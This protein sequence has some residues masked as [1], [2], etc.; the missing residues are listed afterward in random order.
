M[1]STAEHLLSIA[2][3]QIGYQ[4]KANNWVKYGTEFGANNEA[5]CQV[6]VWWVFKHSGA[7]S[8]MLQNSVTRIAYPWFKKHHTM[9]PVAQARPGDV[10]WF[11]FSKELKPVSHVGIVEKNLGDGVLQTIEGNTTRNGQ[12]GPEGVYRRRRHSHIVAVGRP[13]LLPATTAA[14]TGTSSAVHVVASGDTMFSI[15]KAWGVSL[16]ALEKANPKAGHPAGNFKNIHPGDKI[17]H[18]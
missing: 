2:R 1:S 15:A 5:W 13:H 7:S 18:P 10:V 4:E 9:V 12:G 3:S 17:V 11:D 8:E 14:H 16:D 6:F